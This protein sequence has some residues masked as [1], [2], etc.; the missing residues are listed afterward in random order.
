[1]KNGPFSSTR[2]GSKKMVNLLE[3]IEEL[4]TPVALKVTSDPCPCESCRRRGKVGWP[5]PLDEPR[6][7]VWTC[8]KHSLA[9]MVHLR[10]LFKRKGAVLQRPLVKNRT[11]ASEELFVA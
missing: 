9:R 11:R 4:P 3:R 7:F 5:E 2:S 10:A 6:R 8:A 1:M